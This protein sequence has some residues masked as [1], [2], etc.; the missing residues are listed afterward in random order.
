MIKHK[1]LFIIC[2]CE[3]QISCSNFL[4]NSSHQQSSSQKQSSQSSKSNSFTFSSTSSCPLIIIN[5][6]CVILASISSQVY[7]DLFIFSI[8]V[9]YLFFYPSPFP[10]SKR[11]NQFQLLIYLCYLSK[12]SY[13][14]MNQSTKY[15]CKMLNRDY[16]QNE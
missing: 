6:Q 11:Y 10:Y 1:S 2:Q 9:F 13:L 7:F 8:Q 12:L 5:L 4:Y 15:S 16:T 14:F 3:T